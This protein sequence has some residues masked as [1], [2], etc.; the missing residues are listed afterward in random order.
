M[1]FQWKYTRP[2]DR[3]SH[4]SF[5]VFSIDGISGSTNS[6]H[7]VS[8]I[9]VV[10]TNWHQTHRLQETDFYYPDLYCRTSSAHLPLCTMVWPLF[11]AEVGTITFYDLDRYQPLFCISLSHDPVMSDVK[12]PLET[13]RQFQMSSMLLL[14][15]N[16]HLS[17]PA[18]PSR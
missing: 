6:G 5:Q 8:R 10:A 18:A 9:P 14:E 15:A 12:A 2:R 3:R 4:H 13:A 1:I 11:V 16:R 17:A 7:E